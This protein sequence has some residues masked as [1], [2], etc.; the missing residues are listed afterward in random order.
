LIANTYKRRSTIPARKS[1][2]SKALSGTSRPC[3]ER[4]ALELTA[5][6]LID[7]PKPPV[8]MTSA[9]KTAWGRFMPSI[10]ALGTATAADIPALRLLAETLAT[11][12]Q[13]KKQLDRDGLV[14]MNAAGGARSHPA[15][16]A[17]GKARAQAERLMGHFGMYPRARNAV[18]AAS[19]PGRN[20]F[21]DI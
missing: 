8:G 1:A 13:A 10:V 2:A 15:L 6:R 7:V 20:D 9:E 18:P 19:D 5:N 21:D 4:A 11:A 16:E 17:L 12:D 14:L 3:R